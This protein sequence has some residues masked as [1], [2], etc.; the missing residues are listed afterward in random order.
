MAKRVLIVDDDPNYRILLRQSLE[1]RGFLVEEAYGGREA[2]RCLVNSHFDLVIA[3]FS[4]E[5]MRGDELCRTIR[6]TEKFKNL[7]VL[8]IP[9]YDNFDKQWFMDRGATDVLYKPI[10]DAVLMDHIRRCLAQS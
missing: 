9:G 7:P 8:I 6:Q 5:N 4:M 2:Y 3:D 10:E 1:R